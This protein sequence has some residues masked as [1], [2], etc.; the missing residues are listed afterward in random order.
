MSKCEEC[1]GSGF[2]IDTL[3]GADG[4]ACHA[5]RP[6]SCYDAAKHGPIPQS[7]PTPKKDIKCDGKDGCG[8]WVHEDKW[9]YTEVGCSDCGSHGAEECPECHAVYDNV[10]DKREMRDAV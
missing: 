1:K 8:E 6:C 7:T 3:F 10:Y 2:V 4:M 9:I 5:I